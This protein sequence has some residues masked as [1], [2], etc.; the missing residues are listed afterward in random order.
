MP[1][2]AAANVRVDDEAAED[3]EVFVHAACA[4][5]EPAVG[6]L[7]AKRKFERT[8]RVND[9]AECVAVT[10]AKGEDTV[11]EAEF[12]GGAIVHRRK[13]VVIGFAT[14][15]DDELLAEAERAVGG[16]A[17]RFD[18]G[19]TLLLQANDDVGLK[20]GNDV[21]VVGREDHAEIAVS[22]EFAE[23]VRDR[24]SRSTM[25]GGAELVAEKRWQLSIVDFRM[26]I[27]L[28]RVVWGYMRRFGLLNGDGASEA[29]AEAFAF[30]E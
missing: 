28:C 22:D 2:T 24:E 4:A 6:R 23:V 5:R 20:I 15:G 29:G 18:N 1:Q 21:V 8:V 30:G 27:G 19:E 12:V 11:D 3:A 25:K 26:S 9:D 10:L 16:D 7:I 14:W 17:L 13:S